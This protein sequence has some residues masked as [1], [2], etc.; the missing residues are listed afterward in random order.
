MI[1]EGRERNEID[2]F[3]ERWNERTIW[4]V[5]QKTSRQG[6]QDGRG[7]FTLELLSSFDSRPINRAWKRPTMFALI[8]PA[9]QIGIGFFEAAL[10]TSSLG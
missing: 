8:T 3:F 5:E 1:S 6:R 4:T 10:R 7:H 9:R 2:P